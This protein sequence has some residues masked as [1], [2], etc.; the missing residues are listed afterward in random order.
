MVAKIVAFGH[1]AFASLKRRNFRLYFI[2]QGISQTGG[3]MQ[4]VAQ[5]WL[6]LHLTGSATALGVVSALQYAPTLFLGPYAGLLIDRVPKRTVLYVTQT[7]AAL[8]ALVLG[9]AVATGTV[10]AWMV[11]V[12]ATLLGLVTAVDYPTRQAFL[13]DLCGPSEVVSAVGLYS[14]AA[15]V[16][17]VLGPAIAGVVIAWAGMPI[18]FFANAISFS[19]VVFC[20]LR[21]DASQ[22][23]PVARMR[24]DTHLS[25]GFAYAWRTPSVR[26]A[27]MIT[28]IVG[29]LTFEFTVT[30]PPL[31]K[32]VLG[33]SAAGLASLM[34]GMGV[35]AAI[36]GVLTAGRGRES[37]AR[38]G[39]ASLA[40]GAATA[41]V[42]V[43]PNIVTATLLMVIVGLFAARFTGLSNAIVQ[44]ASSPRQRNRM[45]ALWSTAFLGSSFLGAPL[46]GWIAESAG[47]R[48]ALEMGLLG[49]MAAA[50]IGWQGTRAVA[51]EAARV[52]ALPPAEDAKAA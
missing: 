32:F 42:G 41:L 16:A 6:V 4:G 37:V 5:A 40:F 26:A 14:T 25:E 35:G 22:F 13:F 1:S 46:V 23:H 36:G 10:R 11:F 43:A 20:L 47:P 17:R 18:C 28:A 52:A 30:L 19:A 29:V 21:M 48:W 27:L 50:V 44:L 9:V 2:G 15:N 8:L 39:M 38:L 3:W 45:T 31:A 34:S 49:G 12:T 51:R 33:G 7:V 24:Q